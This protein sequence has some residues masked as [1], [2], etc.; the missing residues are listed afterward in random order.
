MD[1]GLPRRL[2]G[3]Q[4]HTAHPHVSRRGLHRAGRLVQEA[5]Q[6]G[7]RLEPY[8]PLV[9]ARHA[10]VRLES[11]APG[12]DAR[13][14][15]GD[16]RVAP[17]DEGDAPVEPPADG[18]LLRRGLGVDVHRDDL[19]VG[20]GRLH[21]EKRLISHPKRRVGVRHEDLPL[22]IQDAHGNSGGRVLDGPA[23]SRV[24]RGVVRGSEEVL[25]TARRGAGRTPSCPRC[26]S[27]T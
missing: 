5:L 13:V 15:R 11:R 27:P 3:I 9:G 20:P 26:G 7:L 6:D 25:G 2:V 12:Q 10:A 24:A 23:A 14:R 22:D 19:Q 4:D 21:L 8:D 18:L 16:V 17:D 1:A